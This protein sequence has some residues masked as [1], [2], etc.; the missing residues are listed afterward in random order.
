MI[1]NRE[2]IAELY[3]GVLDYDLDG[4]LPVLNR[5]FLNTICFII[6]NNPEVVSEPPNYGT[7]W[8]ST[9]GHHI[10]IKDIS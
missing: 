4:H 1:L 5:E 6:E 7:R 3:L 9:V 2:K 10:D 8:I